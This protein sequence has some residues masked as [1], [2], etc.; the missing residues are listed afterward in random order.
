MR[1]KSGK[2]LLLFIFNTV[3]TT[4]VNAADI[5]F[6]KYGYGK[7][8]W[9]DKSSTF[10]PAIYPLK[11]S[12]AYDKLMQRQ[13]RATT[14]N[15][16]PYYDVNEWDNNQTQKDRAI[17]ASLKVWQKKHD[18]LSQVKIHNE[19]GR[20]YFIYRG[21]LP[22]LAGPVS[23]GVMCGSDFRLTTGDIKLDYLGHSCD[24]GNDLQNNWVEI[25]SGDELSFIVKLNL[26]YEFLPGKHQYQVGSLEYEV[27]TK[28]WF[29]EVISNA[30]MFSIFNRRSECPIKTELPIVIKE[31]SLCPQYEFRTNDLESIMNDLGFDGDNSNNYFQIR[32]NQVSITI[33]ADEN[34][35]YYHFL[36][37]TKSGY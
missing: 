27:V 33:D 35:S 34:T 31:Q 12:Y 15:L 10:D 16:N 26:A 5:I 14:A 13:P 2:L 24:F 21:G 25:E 19:S 6:M 7:I 22:S 23:F 20:S 32:T 17:V 11:D 8:Y 3:L 37:S 36:R 28:E 1:V 29:T 4:S 30:T 9:G 18:V